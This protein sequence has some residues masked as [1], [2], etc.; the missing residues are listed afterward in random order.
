MLCTRISLFPPANKYT[1]ILQGQKIGVN[2]NLKKYKS[3]TRE[4]K[5]QH[6][7]SQPTIE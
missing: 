5:E 6:N 3:W 7:T 1:Q 2:D 4:S